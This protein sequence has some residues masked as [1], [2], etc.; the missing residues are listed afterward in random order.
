MNLL[1]L[2]PRQPAQLFLSEFPEMRTLRLMLRQKHTPPP[3]PL[4]REG[5][6]SSLAAGRPAPAALL[7]T[8]L[9][10]PDV[11]GCLNQHVAGE[12]RGRP[13]SHEFCPSGFLLSLPPACEPGTFST[14]S[15]DFSSKDTAADVRPGSASLGEPRP[16]T[17]SLSLGP[18]GVECSHLCAAGLP[19]RSRSLPPPAAGF[20]CLC[21]NLNG[22]NILS[23]VLHVGYCLLTP[24]GTRPLRS[25][26]SRDA[27]SLE[28]PSSTHERCPA[29]V[30]LEP[31]K[32]F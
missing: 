31:V 24:K 3:P 1:C 7:S 12:R 9:N 15:I 32:P 16:P 14:W 13:L 23:V 11:R 30:K 26:T 17:L 21:N 22:F 2:P 10:R 18:G 29:T 27:E 25:Q 8:P 4:F 6:T 20:P 19:W 5:C 28:N